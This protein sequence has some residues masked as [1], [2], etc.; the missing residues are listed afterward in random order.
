[1]KNKLNMT[2]RIK[3]PVFWVQ[4]VVAFI[5]CALAYNQMEPQD[6]T[7][8]AGLFSL[9]VGVLKNPYC[10]ALCVW[11]IFNAV[12]DPTTKGVTDSSRAMKYE[13]PYED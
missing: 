13:K 4:I 7:T 2:V 3:N 12:N 1:M 5:M 8:W 11:N 10:L 9:V 6:L